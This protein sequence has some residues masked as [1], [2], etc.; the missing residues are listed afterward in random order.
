MD[1]DRRFDTAA[2]AAG[3][4][5]IDAGTGDVVSPIHLASTFGLS[6]LDPD[7]GLD[8]RDP[9]AGEF[10][11]SR[12]SNPTR[13]TLEERLAELA[14]GDRAFAFSSGT[15]AIATTMLAV[16]EPGDHVVAF[17]D[18]YAG[19]RRM[20]ET[21]F[22]AKLDVAVEFVDATDPEAVSAALRP[23]TSLVWMESPTN[24]LLKLCDIGAI[25]GAVGDSAVL[26]VDNTFLSPTSSSRS[27]WVRASWSTARRNTSTATPTRSAARRSRA[28][29]TSRRRSSSTSRSGWA[30]CS[31]RSTPTSSCAG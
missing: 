8:D 30:T 31:R 10:L 5:G 27:I 9:A 16:V 6:E 20:L 26:G 28:I 2:I 17:G 15:A 19:T 18:L 4:E 12:L 21:L 1:E 11:Y 29:P 3:G 14:G 25:A 7:V 13:H 23:E 22:E 24:P